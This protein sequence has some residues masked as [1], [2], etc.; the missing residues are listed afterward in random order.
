LRGRLEITF[1][2]VRY[3]WD[4]VLQDWEE[5]IWDIPNVKSNHPEKTIHPAQF[6][7]ELVQ[8]PILALTNE[9]DVVLDP[10]GGVGSSALAALLLNR[11]AVSIDRDENYTRIAYERVKEMVNGTLRIRKIGTKIYTPTGKEKV[12]RV[13]EGW[14]KNESN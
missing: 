9:G 3:F 1:M 4:I 10:Y 14:A 11:K 6:P 7:I 13:P 8:R 5:Q 2:I 12:A